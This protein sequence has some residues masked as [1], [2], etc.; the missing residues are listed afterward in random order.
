MNYKGANFEY[1]NLS[2]GTSFKEMAKAKAC[3]SIYLKT[4]NTPKNLIH[5]LERKE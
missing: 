2:L 4:S 3:S 1:I 5:T